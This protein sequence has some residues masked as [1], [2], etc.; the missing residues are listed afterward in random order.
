M[1]DVS[2][3][4]VSWNVADLLDACLRSIVTGPVAVVPP[5]REVSTEDGRVSVEIIVVE[6]ASTD[7]SAAV[8]ARYPEV[9][10][11]AQPENVGFTRGNNLGL[12]VARGRYVMLL[13]PDTEVLVDAIPVLAA[14]LD[15]HP[16]VGI[17]G[18]HTLNTDGS[19]QS[20]RRQFPGLITALFESTWL[21][22][23]APP[24]LLRRYYMDDAPDDGI[25]DVGWMQGSALMVRREVVE[26]IGGLDEGY[27]MYSEEMDWCKR[28]ADAGWRLVYVGAAQIVHHGGKSSEQVVS[29]RHIYFQQSK[30]RY[31]CKHHGRLAGELLRWYL[32]AQY[33][34][35]IGLEGLKALVGHK[36]A[37]R[38]ERMAA[39]W[40][41]LRSGL[42]S[43]R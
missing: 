11:L 39:Y 23:I 20:T 38:R 29:R 27:V 13:N 35:Q 4:I 30:V 22:G 21:Q 24:G 8:L 1:I 14:Y 40:Q 37:M 33:A 5:D 32:L 9:R 6:N 19:T 3:I 26:Q 10:V 28:A 18:P 43:E 34:W 25:F 42:R 2:I 15:A 41:V 16:D 12:A 7:H 31:F 17:V 36:R